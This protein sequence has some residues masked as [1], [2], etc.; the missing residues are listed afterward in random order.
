MIHFLVIVFV[1]MY[2]FVSH[3]RDYDVL[4]TIQEMNFY[5]DRS[6]LKSNSTSAYAED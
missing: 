5:E 4:V 3:E 2:F 1:L 6:F